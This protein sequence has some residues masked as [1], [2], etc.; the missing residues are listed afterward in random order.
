MSPATRRA[1]AENDG[2]FRLAAAIL[3]GRRLTGMFL[4]AFTKRVAEHLEIA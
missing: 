1:S 3:N 4:T 2:Y